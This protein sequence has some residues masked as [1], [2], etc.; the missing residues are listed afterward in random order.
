MDNVPQEPGLYF[1]KSN[2]D[3]WWDLIVNVQGESP[4]LYIDHIYSR[5]GASGPRIIVESTK[6]KFSDSFTTAMDL[7]TQSR[8]KNLPKKPA[9]F[10][11]RK[12][13]L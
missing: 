11:S 3:G 13:V 6:N 12:T 4:M 5:G 7:E 10:I 1:A 9:S 8:I 2:K